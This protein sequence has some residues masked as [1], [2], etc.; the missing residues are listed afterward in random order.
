MESTKKTTKPTPKVK[1]ALT[2]KKPRATLKSPIV[3]EMTE[4]DHSFSQKD[5]CGAKHKRNEKA[6]YLLMIV[7]LLVNFVLAWV[8][9][10]KLTTLHDWMVMGAGGVENLKTL[11]TIY[12]TP[13]YQ[14]YF[15]G[16]ITNLQTKIQTLNPTP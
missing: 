9:I 2:E 8:V 1:K 4:L 5:C 11:E 6:I 16:E 3:E 15:R 10:C 7:F 12:Q 13:E 14:E